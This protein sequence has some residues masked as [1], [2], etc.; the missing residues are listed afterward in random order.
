MA[1]K[2]F[3]STELEYSKAAVALAKDFSVLDEDLPEIDEP[4]FVQLFL[5]ILASEEPD[6]DLSPWL[7]VCRRSSSPVRVYRVE[8]GAKK[9]LFKVP[10]LLDA[11]GVTK[12]IYTKSRSMSHLV[13]SAMLEAQARPA[14]MADAIVTKHLQQADVG[15]VQLNAK[16]EAM[17]N[18][19]FRKYGY[20]PISDTL[21]EDSTLEP[22]DGTVVGKAST[23]SKP[24]FSVA[25]EGFDESDW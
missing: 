18:Y 9:Y 25:V 10:A 5:P 22:L 7:A 1:S 6:V 23:Y 15:R 12:T 13:T 24:S 20:A 19:I 2:Q 11:Q 16:A 4:H 17:W 14:K 8:N 3:S 21:P